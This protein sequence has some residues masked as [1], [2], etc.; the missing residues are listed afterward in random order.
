MYYHYYF[1]YSVKPD[2]RPSPL[3]DEH[4]FIGLDNLA[5]PTRASD[6]DAAAQLV[7]R[8]ENAVA[9][10]K[11]PFIAG[12]LARFDESQGKWTFTNPA[13]YPSAVAGSFR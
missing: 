11:T 1:L 6:A 5:R 13:L 9:K 4:G 10:L 2:E 3:I 8:T 12:V 7:Q